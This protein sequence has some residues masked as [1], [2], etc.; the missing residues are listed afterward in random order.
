MA[1]YVLTTAGFGSNTTY[2][3]SGIYFPVTVLAMTSGGRS[4]PKFIGCGHVVFRNP[5]NGT[6][7]RNIDPWNGGSTSFYN[8]NFVDM[9][10]WLT[11]DLRYPWRFENCGF[12]GQLFGYAG[13]SLGA[14][15]FINCSCATGVI[16]PN[17]TETIFQ[18]DTAT[19]IKPTTAQLVW[20]NTTT[21]IRNITGCT[22][23]APGLILPASTNSAEPM[24]G[25][26]NC[27]PD[28]YQS[29]V[30]GGLF[31]DY[32]V[33]SARLVNDSNTDNFLASTLGWIKDPT[34]PG[35]LDLS[36]STIS[37]TGGDGV[38]LLSPVY[39][40]NYGVTL[41]GVGINITEL[42]DG[43]TAQT[44]DSDPLNNT[45]KIEYRVSD[46]AFLQTD[47]ESPAWTLLER[48]KLDYSIQGKY[49]QFRLVFQLNAAI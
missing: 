14:F 38:G 5:N 49:I 34:T 3:K 47:T 19:L 18:N 11:G 8:I 7:T 28:K 16:I 46:T 22:Y 41:K 12:K 43:G 23:V 40:F 30:T 42:T 2:F 6:F 15:D 9:N 10:C 29:S 39:Y 25:C 32:P 1:Y 20:N 4:D 45:R 26:V 21:D 27:I 13:G 17:N 36:N 35:T 33:A 44:I 37:V 48:K 31:V 24:M